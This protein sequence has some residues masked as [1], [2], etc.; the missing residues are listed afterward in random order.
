MRWPPLHAVKYKKLEGS[1]PQVL[2]MVPVEGARFYLRR[3]S[4][5]PESRVDPTVKRDD[6]EGERG[7][8]KA[9]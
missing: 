6:G 7:L 2:E 5:D 3:K 1:Y 4:D 8:D 9:V